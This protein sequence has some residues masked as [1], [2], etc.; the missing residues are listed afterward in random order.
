MAAPA[1]LL[2]TALFNAILARKTGAGYT[3]ITDFELQETQL[4]SVTLPQ[5]KSGILVSVI[6]LGGDRRLRSRGGMYELH[7]PVQVA[8]QAL[9]NP[10][11]LWEINRLIDFTDELIDTAG[12]LD[13][14]DWQETN[15]LKDQQ[16]V[17]YDYVR[18][19]EHSEYLAVFMPQYLMYGGTD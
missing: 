14:W 7:Q 6:G 11:H 12:D 18:L 2:R 16:G 3:D 9:I 1:R 8:V 19:R 13:G 10:R 15:V 17:P 5:L 4:P